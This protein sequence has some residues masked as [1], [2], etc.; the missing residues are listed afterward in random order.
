MNYLGSFFV[1]I[2]K[3]WE[4]AALYVVFTLL[5][6]LSSCKRPIVAPNSPVKIG[7]RE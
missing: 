2:D 6:L 1:L 4:V 3:R 5:C 7:S